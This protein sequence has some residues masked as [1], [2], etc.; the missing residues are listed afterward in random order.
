MTRENYEQIT[1][2]GRGAV[3]LLTL[4]RPERLNAWTPQMMRELVRAVRDANAD[5]AIGAIVV[6]GAGRGFCAGA[7]I[8]L[9]FAPALD[10]AGQGR[11]DPSLPITDDWVRL[12]RESKPMVAAINGPA[13]GV[14]LTMVLP[15]DYLV[16]AQGAKLSARFIKMGLVPELASSHFLV[17]RCGWGAASWLALSGTTVLADEAARLRLVDRVVPPEDVLAEALAVAAELAANPAPQLLMV[18]ELL[19]RNANERNLEVVQQR[20]LEALSVASKTPEHRVAVKAFLERRAPHVATL[21]SPGR[22]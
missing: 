8:G 18:K 4:N 6:T 7:D 14:G 11:R 1:V 2:E 12:C 3:I 13:V 15:F 9:Q 10:G 17:L 16:A 20:E 22:D 5:P 21:P 19:T